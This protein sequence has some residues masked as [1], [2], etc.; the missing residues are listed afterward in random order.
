QGM[1]KLVWSTTRVAGG[2]P[3]TGTL[4]K[5]PS[6]TGPFQNVP[7][8]DFISALSGQ[9]QPRSP[10]LYQDV[11]VIGYR[12][13]SGDVPIATLH[14]TITASGGSIDAAA[15]S[16]GDFVK[17]VSLPIPSGGDAAWIQFEF[18]QAVS[19]RGISVAMSGFKWPF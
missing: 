7:L 9:T 4:P 17:G 16:D 3:F 5:P 11:A 13:P 6:T 15:L 18:P 10:E 12:V 8:F 14:P 1:K 19:V 2:R